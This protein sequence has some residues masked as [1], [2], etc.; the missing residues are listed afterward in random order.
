[1]EG[2]LDKDIHLNYAEVKSQECSVSLF[3]ASAFKRLIME[4]DT[5]RWYVLNQFAKRRRWAEANLPLMKMPDTRRRIMIVLTRFALELG[6]RAESVI[7]FECPLT[8]QEMAQLIGLSR[9]TFTEVLLQLQKEGIVSI[10][11]KRWSIKDLEQ[12]C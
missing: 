9:Q 7:S 2:L 1:M 11:R 4:N 3:P 8:R 12:N 10:D 6:E 5:V